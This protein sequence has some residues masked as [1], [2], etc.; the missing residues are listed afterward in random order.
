MAN[1]F[2]DKGANHFLTGDI[3]V[4]SDTIKANLI[5]SASYTPSFSADEFLSDIPGGAIIAAGVALS[6]KT[7]SAGALSAANVIWTSVTGGAAAYIGLYKDT[8]TGSTSNLIGLI[9]TG[10]GLPV[11]PNG[12]DITAAWPSGLI[13]TLKLSL[14]SAERRR[15]ARERWARIF[16][17]VI[18]GGRG[19]EEAAKWE[20]PILTKS[21]P[22]LGLIHPVGRAW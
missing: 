11:T 4:S 3:D 6:S 15:K 8:G 5:S 12:G 2:Y 18:G 7:T 20:T 22:R 14:A 17:E 10:T 21:E 13:F 1:K 9:D 16:D 19:M